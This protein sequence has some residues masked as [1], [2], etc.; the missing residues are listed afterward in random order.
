MTAVDFDLDGKVTVLSAMLNALVDFGNEDG[1]SFYAGIGFGRARVKALGDK[2]SAWAGQL[3]AGVRYAIS[4]NID[5]GLK[6]RYFRTGK[7]DLVEDS[8]LALLGNT[9]TRTVLDVT[10]APVT[11]TRTTD[12]LLFA[13]MEDKFRSHSLAIRRWRWR[14]PVRLR[15]AVCASPSS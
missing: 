15:I 1:L 7:V 9:E 8:A 4:D 2:D 5:L 11:V 10:G 3:I 12:A 13:D 6:Y 14:A